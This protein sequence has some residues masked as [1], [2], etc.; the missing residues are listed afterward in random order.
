M[1][2]KLGIEIILINL[3]K[4]IVIF[5]VAAQVNLLK[6]SL[7]MILVFASIRKSSFGLHAQNSIVCTITSLTIDVFGAFISYYITLNNFMVFIIF[8]FINICLYRYAPADTEN[9]PLIG[10]KLR[11]NLRRQSVT[12]GIILMILTLIIQNPTVKAMIIIAT[13]AQVISILPITYRILNRG[14]KNYEK[15]ERG[16]N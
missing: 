13:G 11:Q 15:Y 14:Y 3:S 1:K 16:I 12:V 5:L 10:K 7:F 6:E 9:H 4:L 8:V 2:M